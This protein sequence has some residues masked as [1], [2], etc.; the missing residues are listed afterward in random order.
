MVHPDL[1]IFLGFY[2]LIW[3][4][5]E[6]KFYKYLSPEKE[7]RDKCDSNSVKSLNNCLFIYYG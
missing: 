3:G 2:I 5:T 1:Q 4:I 7:K 6:F